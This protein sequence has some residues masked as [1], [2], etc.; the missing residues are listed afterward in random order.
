V[1]PSNSEPGLLTILEAAGILRLKPS[2]LRAW[3][4]KRRIPFVKLGSR[5]FFRRADVSSLIESSTVPAR[6]DWNV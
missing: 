6:E 2:T 4:L 5:V 3:I 1:H